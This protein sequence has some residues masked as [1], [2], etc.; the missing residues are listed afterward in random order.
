MNA[1]PDDPIS[2]FYEEHPYPPPVS[3]LDAFAA[4]WDDPL[5]RTSEYHRLFP[6]RPYRED[7]RI[8]VAGCGTSQAARQALKWP[9]ATVVGIDVSASS[10]AATEQLRDRYELRNLQLHELPID[11]VASLDLPFDLV[12]CTGVVH[13]LADP[14]A[15]LAALRQTLAPRG[16]LHL[17]VYGRHGRAGISML[18][19]YCRIMG[20][21]PSEAQLDDLVETLRE[22]PIDHPISRQLRGSPDFRRNDALA[23]ALLNPRERT[24]A[25]DELMDLLAAAGL[26]FGRWYRQAPY[27]SQCGAIA[28]TPHAARLAAGR[29]RRARPT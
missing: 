24:Y 15:G 26:R 3:D 18:R 21:E 23:D 22:V 25:V 16:A 13:H 9:N 17:M 10:L 4:R 6:E 27:R 2:S 14:A 11:D 7:L 20:V 5:R 1:S 12:V 8:L 19:E 28:T 29:T